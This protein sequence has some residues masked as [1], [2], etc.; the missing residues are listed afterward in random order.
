MS[1][2]PQV[3]QPQQQVNAP[4]VEQPQAEQQQ[5]QE[6]PPTEQQANQQQVEQP[7][8][9]QQIEQTQVNEKKEDPNKLT[10]RE[11]INLNKMT[12]VIERIPKMV[13][14]LETTQKKMIDLKKFVEEKMFEPKENETLEENIIRHKNIVDRI[15][16][17]DIKSDEYIK[18]SETMVT[19]L[20][21]T[22]QLFQNIVDNQP[23][24]KAKV[25]KY[26]NEIIHERNK[27]VDKK[28]QDPIDALKEQIRQQ[29]K[30]R[31]NMKNEMEL[32]WIELDEEKALRH[33]ND[34]KESIVKSKKEAQKTIENAY[35]I[36]GIDKDPKLF[37]SVHPELEDLMTIEE[38]R[39]LEEWTGLS[40]A[41]ICFNTAD[42]DQWQ[43]NNSMFSGCLLKRK[44]VAI[45]ITETNGN[46]FGGFISQKINKPNTWINDSKAFLF[47]LQSNNRLN[48]MKR[49]DI[50]NPE[51]AFHLY[52]ISNELLVDFGST[53]LRIYKS[54]NISSSSHSSQTSYNYDGIELALIGNNNAFTISS[55]LVIQME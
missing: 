7:T 52:D 27:L 36:N 43:Q 35:I 1:E 5:V 8:Q 18:W 54:N 29:E 14:E 31:A 34:L 47:N 28:F 22:S 30:E 25:K 49:F 48:E 24:D 12:Q 13:N 37:Y 32:R 42:D 50:K 26:K 21:T 17:I 10:I 46:K 6:Q 23:E 41:D 9:E 20:N 45:V 51:N 19:E 40:V 15:E 16:A 2:V 11:M 53:D 3:E 4:P 39:K 33:Q 38:C 44:N 55:I